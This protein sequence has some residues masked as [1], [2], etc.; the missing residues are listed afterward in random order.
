M[1]KIRK[2]NPSIY[3]QK[4]PTVIGLF[5]FYLYFLK[6]NIVLRIVNKTVDLIK[7]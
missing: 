3:P 2:V 7:D 4:S 6:N 1:K 5:F